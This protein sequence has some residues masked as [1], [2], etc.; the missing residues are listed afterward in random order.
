[1]RQVHQSPRMRQVHESPQWCD[2]TVHQAAEWE[3]YW[4]SSKSSVF[5]VTSSCATIP[6]HQH[7]KQTDTHIKSFMTQCCRRSDWR[8]QIPHTITMNYHHTHAPYT[9][10]I[11]YVVECTYPRRRSWQDGRG[12]APAHATAQESRHETRQGSQV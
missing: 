1:M 6:T 3:R 8:C 10:G 2:E 7:T 5:S 9:M 11:V 4:T 12:S